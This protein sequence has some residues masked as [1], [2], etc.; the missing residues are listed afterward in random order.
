MKKT[1]R[2]MKSV[3]VSFL[4]LTG[5]LVL[6]TSCKKDDDVTLE[7]TS[8]KLVSGGN[9]EADFT[10]ELTQPIV[11]QVTDQNG[12]PF[13]GATL[14]FAVTEGAVSAQTAIT[15]NEGKATVS[16]TLGETFGQQSLTVTLNATDNT[17][18]KPL[19]VN[20]TSLASVT[21]VDGNL[22]KVVKIGDQ[23]WMA[24]NL[25][26]TKYNDGSDIPNITDNTEWK[27][28]TDGAYCWHKNDI[29]TYKELGALYN[30]HV[31]GTGKLAPKGWHVPTEK[32]FDI[33]EMN[34]GLS[35]EDAAIIGWR[36][37]T[38]QIGYKLKSVNGWD[39]NGN[40]INEFGFNSFPSGLKYWDARTF[41][42]STEIAS[43]YWSQTLN[44]D[45]NAMRLQL[46]ST[47]NGSHKEFFYKNYGIN[48]RCIKD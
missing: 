21:D 17:K 43:W 29:D 9:Q 10:T 1:M 14:T 42:P 38:E 34:H 20:A 40:G 45:E 28:A 24:E 30:W 5:L 27:N 31:V 6:A 39:G 3:F 19:T 32:E 25:K 41:Y 7:A 11:V 8:I 12:N 37:E 44:T 22:Y 35:E 47:K 18:T 15:N 36:G 33:L 4:I 16:W 2:K 46:S 23:F 48:V 13:N 26:T